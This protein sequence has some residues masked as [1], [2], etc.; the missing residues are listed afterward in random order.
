MDRVIYDYIE[1]DIETGKT[2][3][4]H[5]F[6][7]TGDVALCGGGGGGDVESVDY[8]YNARMAT[9]AEKQHEW[10]EDYYNMWKNNGFKAYEIE[11][12]KANRAALPYESKLYTSGL[13]TASSLLP[14][15]E[16]LARSQIQN[17]MDMQP[18]RNAAERRY[19]S[20]AAQGVDVNERVGQAQA[21]VVNAWAGLD[22]ARNREMARMGV[23]PDSGRY[24]GVYAEQQAKQAA[25][26]ADARNKARFAGEEE[27]YQRRRDAATYASQS[28]SNNDMSALNSIMQGIGL[29]RG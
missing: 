24:A 15:Q 6:V 7:Y 2:V 23:N 12:V 25:Q 26:I 1:I 19:L 28:A 16:R 17:A 18:D 22:D 5:S 9:I 20:D 4:E 10:A 14:M 3:K 29:I 21:D 27:S 13:K 8:D 11:Q